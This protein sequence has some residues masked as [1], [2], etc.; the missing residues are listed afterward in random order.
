MITAVDTS[1]L[2][3]ILID[4]SSFMAQSE[5][6]LRDFREMSDLI[7]CE[8][9]IAEI[10]PVFSNDQHL[11]DFLQDLQIE[12]TPSSIKTILLAGSMYAEYI[13]NKGPSKRVLPDF[14]IGAHALQQADILLAR[15]RGYYC[16]YFKDLKLVDPALC[17]DE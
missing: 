3:D 14:M 15:D 13:S 7:V 17:G 2:L 6:Q 10:R 9:V 8:A 4:G 5:F 1:V 12:F 16:E 11:I